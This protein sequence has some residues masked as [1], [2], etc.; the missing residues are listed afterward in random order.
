MGARGR[1]PVPM[2]ERAIG[3]GDYRPNNVYRAVLSDPVKPAEVDADPIQSA[4][5]DEL[6]IALGEQKKLTRHDTDVLLMA[7]QSWAMMVEAKKLLAR[8]GLLL[9]GRDGNPI[10]N[11][12]SMIF[13]KQQTHYLHLLREMGLTPA[14]RSRVN[15]VEEQNTDALQDFTEALDTADSSQS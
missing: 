5:W 4:K 3:D 8:D 2:H 12:A 7:C 10:K 6:V 9:K 14:S 11:P 15:S 13:D 1:N